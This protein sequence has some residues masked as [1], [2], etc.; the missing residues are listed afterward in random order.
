MNE[1][2]Q[3]AAAITLIAA[4]PGYQQAAGD[5]QRAAIHIDS[6]LVDR[7]RASLRGVITLGPEPFAGPEPEAL[8]GL[9]ATLVHEH[10]HTRQNPFRKTASFWRGVVT[11]AHPMRDYEWP[12]YQRQAAF[13]RALATARPDLR[14]AAERERAAVLATFQ[15]VYGAPPPGPGRKG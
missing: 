9:A 1:V 13:L 15:A 11:R 4:V 2:T 8:V 5:L 6:R 12:A 14:A 3:I 10:W 7:G